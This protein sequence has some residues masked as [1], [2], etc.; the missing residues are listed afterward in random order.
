MLISIIETINDCLV[1]WCRWD[2]I[3]LFNQVFVLH[4]TSGHVMMTLLFFVAVELIGLLCY[5]VLVYSFNYLCLFVSVH[6]MSEIIINHHQ[7]S[8]LFN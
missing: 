3:F 6:L 7:S 5:L 4:Q 8:N 1:C 2:F